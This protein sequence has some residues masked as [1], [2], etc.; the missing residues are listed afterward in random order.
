MESTCEL[1]KLIVVRMRDGVY[2]LRT[3]DV[4][5][6]DQVKK[7]HKGTSILLQKDGRD[8][9]VHFLNQPRLQRGHVFLALEIQAKGLISGPID[10]KKQNKN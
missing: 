3:A 7:L 8:A 10:P 4:L 2:K 6:D 9:T 1:L 5:V